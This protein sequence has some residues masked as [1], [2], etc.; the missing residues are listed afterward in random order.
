MLKLIK[1]LFA[2]KRLVTLGGSIEGEI[3]VLDT[4][5]KEDVEYVVL[6]S[7][8]DTLPGGQQSMFWNS[9]S[10]HA[11]VE[12]ISRSNSENRVFR[13]I[14]NYGSE[15]SPGSKVWISGWI[16]Q[17]PEDFGLSG[18]E[19]VPMPN[20]TLAYQQLK[21]HSWVIHVHGRNASRAE[22]LRNFR[23]I[24]ECGYSQLS[25]SLESDAKPDGLGTTRSN[26]GLTEWH[27]VEMAV[28][29]VQSRG[30]KAIVLLGFSLGA[31]IIG[32]FIKHSSYAENISG[33]VFDSPLI[34]FESTMALQARKAGESEQLAKYLLLKMK[35]SRLF[36]YFRLGVPE[37]PTLLTP[38]A[39][40]LLVFYAMTDGYVSMDR[41]PQLQF[42]NP[43][44]NFVHFQNGRHCRLYNQEPERYTKELVSFLKQVET[45]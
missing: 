24:G 41:M 34:D 33:V 15:I 26:L 13:V 17:T 5:R 11:L 42:L 10:G 3:R 36:R 39:K 40:P 31:M 44:G 9:R 19:Q 8:A 35:S 25:I 16:G 27:Q 12:P 45:S 7:S 1:A 28:R 23:A 20:K 21:G 2:A 4:F 6:P 32:Q 22:T 18:V 14:R 30:A 29:Y 43:H 37:I 38:I